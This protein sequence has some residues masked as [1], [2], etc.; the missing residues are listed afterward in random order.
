MAERLSG[1]KTIVIGVPGA[2]TPTCSN[3]HVPGYLAQ[4]A[5]L[6]AK[7]SMKSWCVVSTMERLWMHGPRIKRSKVP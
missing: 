3:Q 4:Q 6:K 7:E 2:F 5:A 1:K